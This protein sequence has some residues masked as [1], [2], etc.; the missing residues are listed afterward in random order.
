MNEFVQDAEKLYHN[1][2]VLDIFCKSQN[3]DPIKIYMEIS[4]KNLIV[5][6]KLCGPIL[7]SD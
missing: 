4:T 7:A 1:L 2:N 3:R 5:A 6:N